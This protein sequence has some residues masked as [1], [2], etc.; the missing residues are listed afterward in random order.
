[1]REKKFYFVVLLLYIV[2]VHIEF[3]VTSGGGTGS[4]CGGYFLEDFETTRNPGPSQIPD[5]DSWTLL[6]MH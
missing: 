1:M 3:L 5:C 2:S 4:G 6:I